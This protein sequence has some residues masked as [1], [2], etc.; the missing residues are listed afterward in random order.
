MEAQLVPTRG[1][2]TGNGIALA[3]GHTTMGRGRECDIVLDDATISRHHA[4]LHNDDHNRYTLVDT[5][6][7]NGI[8][9][10]RRP[11]SQ[12]VELADGDEIW[13][14]KARFAFQRPVGP[15]RITLDAV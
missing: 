3:N 4:E 2:R 12:K 1:P 10:N 8:Y 7:L 13:V 15:R 9:L 11:L 5:G 6:S 14:G